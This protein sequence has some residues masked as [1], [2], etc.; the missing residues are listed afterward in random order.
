MTCFRGQYVSELWPFRLTFLYFVVHGMLLSSLT[1]CNTSSFFTWSILTDLLHH[2]P[3]PQRYFWSI[4][5]SVQ[6]S[7]HMKLC[8]K[9]SI[10][11]VSAWSSSAI[12]WWQS[13]LFECRF[14]HVN[15]GFNFTFT[16]CIVC[17]HATQT[18]EMFHILQ[19]FL[20]YHNVYCVGLFFI[21]ITIVFSTFVSIP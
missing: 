14:C 20:F 5:W 19:L 13:L 11:L 18:V 9:G 10:L 3:A 8:S 17:Y 2:S 4:F 6:V 12:F 1:P 21:L 7:F 16:S 15:P